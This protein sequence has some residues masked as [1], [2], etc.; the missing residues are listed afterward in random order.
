MLA[1]QNHKTT[2]QLYQTIITMIKFHKV[3][4]QSM[5]IQSITTLN[6]MIKSSKFSLAG[7]RSLLVDAT[8]RYN[9]IQNHIKKWESFR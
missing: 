3:M 5:E 7:H 6:I 8:Q 2:L 1:K 9:I 4:C